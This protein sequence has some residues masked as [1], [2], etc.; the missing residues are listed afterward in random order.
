[1]C[2]K[3][4]QVVEG[5]QRPSKDVEAIHDFFMSL[6]VAYQSLDILGQWLDANQRMADLLGFDDPEQMLGR[7]FTQYWSEKTR[8]E[9]PFEKFKQTGRLNGEQ[10]LVRRDGTEIPVLIVG[11]I[12]RDSDGNFMRTHCAL[13]DIT[14]RKKIEE[15]IVRLNTDLERKVEERTRELEEANRA[16]AELARHD[17]LTGLP[18][19]LAANERLET[20]FALLRRSGLPYSLLM[21]DVDHFK[22]VNDRHGHAVG[23]RVL[24]EIGRLFVANLRSSD[25][26]CRFGGEEFLALL[27]HTRTPEARNVAEKLRLAVET[28]SILGATV[29]IGVSTASPDDANCDVAVQCADDQLYKAKNAGRNTVS[30]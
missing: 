12:E 3:L 1:M 5:E 8:K 15:E 27:P 20:E 23:D 4:N 9:N 18:N 16:L 10:L 17:P 22:S 26:V 7:N 19:R 28:A 11:R 6:P 30:A 25:F 24:E 21:I 14:E 13:F 2:K 29:S